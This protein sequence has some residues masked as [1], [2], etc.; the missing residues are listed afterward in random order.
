[1]KNRIPDYLPVQRNKAQSPP[2][3]FQGLRDMGEKQI[4]YRIRQVKSYI[5][6][7]PVTGIG[8]AFC[9]GILLGWFNKRK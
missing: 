8:A 5:Q 3:V 1:M 9:L 7:H 2:A 4:T 6:V